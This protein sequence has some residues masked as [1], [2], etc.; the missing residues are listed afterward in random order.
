[1]CNESGRSSETHATRN[2]AR[3]S[4][5]ARSVVRVWGLRRL[6]GL[7]RRGED[8]N[9]PEKAKK[10]PEIVR[11]RAKSTKGGGWRRQPWHVGLR[12]PFGPSRSL[13][14]N[15]SATSDNCS[16]SPVFVQCKILLLQRH[17]F[18]VSRCI[19]LLP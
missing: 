6:A 9:L 16:L 7:R 13:I 14:G 4:H 1:M 8:A 5:A 2:I 17:N 18:V 19:C 10:K 12:G 15:Q 3:N 11:S